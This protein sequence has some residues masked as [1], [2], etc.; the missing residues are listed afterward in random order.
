MAAAAE[1]VAAVQAR[2][3]R[4]RAEESAA[5]AEAVEAAEAEAETA[6]D[7]KGGN[8]VEAASAIVASVSQK[9]RETE[10]ELAV[11]RGLLKEE[12]AAHAAS[13]ERIARLEGGGAAQGGAQSSA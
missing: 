13:R 12:R 10:N 1:E 11:V 8:V 3:G 4:A 2:L 5:A 9:L 6:P 7:G